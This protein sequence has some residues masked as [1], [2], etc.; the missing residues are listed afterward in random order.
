[1]SNKNA[2]TYVYIKNLC[3]HG[4]II[5]DSLNVE[6]TQFIVKTL[7]LLYVDYLIAITDYN[8]V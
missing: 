3:I 4:N 5:C 7:K 8:Y 2:C 1:M 6:T